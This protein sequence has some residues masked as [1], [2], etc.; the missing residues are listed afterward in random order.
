MSGHI[1]L[2]GLLATYVSLQS[3][4]Q[5]YRLCSYKEELA[6]K[7]SN[8]SSAW[9]LKWEKHI[10]KCT[11][12]TNCM[13]DECSQRN[14]GSFIALCWSTTVSGAS[15]HSKISTCVP[16]CNYGL[17]LNAHGNLLGNLSVLLIL[18]TL[19]YPTPAF[20]SASFATTSYRGRDIQRY[21][22]TCTCHHYDD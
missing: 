21:H 13:F 15:T 17:C 20:D 5:I 10:N 11:Y 9:I 1:I 3:H 2:I 6:K 19:Y 4:S 22:H 18:C 7:L 12:L 8:C 14:W 16:I